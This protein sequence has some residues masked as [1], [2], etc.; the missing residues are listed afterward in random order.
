[1]VLM[2]TSAFVVVYCYFAI[3]RLGCFG[4][5]GLTRKRICEAARM[6][7]DGRLR[8]YDLSHRSNSNVAGSLVGMVALSGDK[9]G[10]TGK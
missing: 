9:Q 1:M 2:L 5:W 10:A 7:A 3:P 6:I 8:S 4:L